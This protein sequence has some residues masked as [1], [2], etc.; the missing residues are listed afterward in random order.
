MLRETAALGST[1]REFRGF[2]TFPKPDGVTDVVI[3][4]SEV[5]AVCPVTGQPA[6]YR[7]KIAYWPID[8]CLESKSLKLY[9]QSFRNEGVFCEALAARIA[10]DTGLALSCA[11][12][13]VIEQTP[14]GGVGIEATAI[15]DHRAR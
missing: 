4:S 6:Q 8:Q 15:A 9:L 7:V 2:D 3:A 5:T 12:E 13:V 11:V 1:V 14:R 10:N